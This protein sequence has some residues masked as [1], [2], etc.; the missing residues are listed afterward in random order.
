MPAAR[1]S[2]APPKKSRRVIFSLSATNKPSVVE[3]L[4]AYESTTE[5]GLVDL[6]IHDMSGIDDGDVAI[7]NDQIGEITRHQAA[8]LI[9]S[10]YPRA[11]YCCAGGPDLGIALACL[12][13]P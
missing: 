12:W 3:C 13:Y 10:S 9:T 5:V 1:L 4:V 2:A 8:C 7:Q 11:I 6:D